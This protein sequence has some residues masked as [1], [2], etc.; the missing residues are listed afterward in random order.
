MNKAA[1]KRLIVVG[2]VIVA[3]AIALFAV[4]GGC[5]HAHGGADCLG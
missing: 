2:L 4:L 5:R 1:K 3:V